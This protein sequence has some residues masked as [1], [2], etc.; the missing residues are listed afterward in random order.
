MTVHL[1]GIRHHGPGSAR[2]V[3]AALDEL[4]PDA[5]LVE[6]PAEAEPLLAMA[7]DVD[8]VPP[9]A[10]L[11]YVAERPERAA[12]YPMAN[13]SPEWCAV[14][15]ALAHGAV[16]RAIDLPLAHSMAMGRDEARD[17]RAEARRPIDPIGRLAHAAG[18][19]DPER[20]WEDVVEHR[21]RPEGAAVPPLDAFA[22]VADAMTAV[23]ETIAPEW[24]GDD[25][26]PS[27]DDRREAHM[28]QIMRGVAKTGTPTIA[29]VCGAWHVPALSGTPDRPL[30]TA[31]ADA[32]L[33]RG[34]AKVKVAMTWVPWTHRR[35]VAA[36]GYGAGVRSPGWYAHVFE[37]PGPAGVPV[38]FGQAARLL[39]ERDVMVSPDHLIAASRLAT[40]TAALRGRPAPGLEE[41]LD[42]AL[43]VLADGRPGPLALIHDELIVGDRLGSV[44]DSTPMVPLAR[45]LL[46]QQKAVRLKPEAAER[47]LELDLR[48]SRGRARSHLLHRLL[49]VGVPWGKPDDGRRSS[50]TFR[51]T[52]RVRWDPELAVSLV[53]ASGYGTTV[54]AAATARLQE[55]VAAADVLADLTALVEVALLADLADA[56]RP[57]MERLAARAANDPD[58]AHLMDALPALVRALR[59]GDVRATDASALRSV[60]DGL[61][62]RVV[63][64][65]VPACASLD[66]ESAAATAERLSATQAALALVD[67]EARRRGWPRVIALV[68][69]GSMTHGLVAGRATRLLH[70]L[71]SWDADAVGRRLSRALSVGTEPAAGAAFVEGFLAASGV[72]L[73]HDGQLLGLIDDWLAALREE[74]FTDVLP[75]LRRTFGSFEVAERRQLGQLVA[76]RG[77][78]RPAAPYGWDVD[79]TRAAA[80]IATVGRLLGAE[81]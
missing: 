69:D 3:V 67:H 68:A 21:G 71:G 11:G 28:R 80:A 46:A 36:A 58:V 13:F 6:L 20:W 50:G 5:V 63:A 62:A 55:R 2:T 26:G 24:S 17:D 23:R 61:V 79:P 15:W 29:V 54:E 39:R 34:L 72:V 44:P 40:A 66:D 53:E 42:A 31:T 49:A 33:L 8:L 27:I 75:L 73:L 74:T 47:T 51:E 81:P 77:D 18:Y 19:D 65:V 35:L 1:L 43:A 60:V 38:W 10:L 59:Y 56:V 16:L 45:D 76:G 70:D 37:H 52:W 57:A 48:T 64:G 22:A 41:V 30:P 9:V 4:Q 14:R 78:G 12:F 25:G 32:A 7:A